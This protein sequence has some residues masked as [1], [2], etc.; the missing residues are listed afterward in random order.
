M[1][2][3]IY[4]LL[5]FAAFSSVFL[6]GW[7]VG[8]WFVQSD[9]KKIDLTDCYTDTCYN[10]Y[11]GGKYTAEHHNKPKKKSNKKSKKR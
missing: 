4:C 9:N 8:C 1:E 10:D 5:G 3:F 6:L 7:Q 11:Y 2:T